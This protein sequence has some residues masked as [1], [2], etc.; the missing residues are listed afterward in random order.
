MKLA[1]WLPAGPPTRCT[2]SFRY[3]SEPVYNL[4][5][6]FLP[7]V[8]HTFPLPVMCTQMPRTF[9][10]VTS[11]SVARPRI[12]VPAKRTFD[13]LFSN[14]MRQVLDIVR[15]FFFAQIFSIFT[16]FAVMFFFSCDA[17]NN[18]CFSIALGTPNTS[19]TIQLRCKYSMTLEEA[20]G[21]AERR[22]KNAK[23]K[24]RL[25][26]SALSWSNSELV[27]PLSKSTF[28]LATRIF[29]R[30]GAAAGVVL[31]INKRV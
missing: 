3:V 2:R 22:K 29:T 16:A 10:S 19:L 31:A 15:L 9:F 12:N 20:T 18:D 13:L 11:V 28:C 6:T 26:Q 5:S 1:I 4:F 7:S 30:V 27:M 8:Q 17:T 24:T 21:R 14:S 23:P 25:S